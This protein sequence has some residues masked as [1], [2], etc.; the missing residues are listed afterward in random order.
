MPA[1]GARPR[2]R[3]PNSIPNRAPPRN[4]RLPRPNPAGEKPNTHRSRTPV[5]TIIDAYNVLHAW[6][7]GPA[8]GSARTELPALA[9]LIAASSYAKQRVTLVCD[10][11]S[12]TGHA[13][14]TRPDPESNA[15]ALYAGPGKDADSLIER[16]VLADTAPKRLTVVS[17]DRRLQRAA[18]KRGG[19]ALPAPAFLA[20]IVRDAAKPPDTPDRPAFA[21]RTPL[22][23]AS[24][25]YWLDV[26]GIDTPPADPGDLLD[27]PLPELPV[28]LRPDHA[29][30]DNAARELADAH[31]PDHPTRDHSNADTPPRPPNTAQHDIINRMLRDL[32]RDLADDP[33]LPDEIRDALINDPAITHSDDADIDALQRWLDEQQH[34]P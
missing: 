11:A 10:G 27:A 19:N 18:R 1:P 14:R 23:N 21:Q 5:H 32:H 34:D 7:T 6:R 20:R 17:S 25:A 4:L 31:N 29:H 13:G 3:E 12:P 2:R 16:L 22:D 28:N 26:F 8:T 30:N 24:T 9:R 15:L 33:T